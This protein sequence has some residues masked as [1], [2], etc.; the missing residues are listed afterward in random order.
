MTQ[1]TTSVPP[2][3]SA[4]YHPRP[5]RRLAIPQRCVRRSAR[6]AF[7]TNQPALGAAPVATAGVH[8]EQRFISR[9][10]PADAAERCVQLP[11]ARTRVRWAE[12][13]RL[14]GEP[15]DGWVAHGGEVRCG[16]RSSSSTS[17]SGVS[18][19][20][21][22]RRRR[23][24][25]STSGTIIEGSEGRALE[26][27]IE[28]A[29]G[30]GS[31]PAPPSIAPRDGAPQRL[32][33]LRASPASSPTSGPALQQWVAL[34]AIAI[35]KRRRRVRIAAR[36]P[37]LPEFGTTRGLGAIASSVAPAAPTGFP[38]LA[39]RDAHRRAHHAC[40]HASVRPR[41]VRAWS[42]SSR[43]HQG[44]G[45]LAAGDVGIRPQARL[46]SSAGRRRDLDRPDPAERSQSLRLSPRRRRRSGSSGSTSSAVISRTRHRYRGARLSHPADAGNLFGGASVLADRAGRG[47]SFST[48]SA[49]STALIVANGDLAQCV[50]N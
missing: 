26:L 27:A 2:L 37:R 10:Q 33:G 29:S 35:V 6:S 24:P 41:R 22:G 47:S 36:P 15:S 45:A 17:G 13:A 11:L 46:S 30:V 20:R 38:P 25:A 34:A 19:R 7:A 4:D 44:G 23:A 50:R 14:H 28:L 42:S 40:P 39:D 16:A 48:S 8:T 12:A 9:T 5:M 31:S 3:E 43:H 1:T 21:S 49:P 32:V 18:A